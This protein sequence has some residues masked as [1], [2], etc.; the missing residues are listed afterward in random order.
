M[1]ARVLA[2]G[3]IALASVFACSDLKRAE[4]VPPGD[5]VDGGDV[6]PPGGDDDSGT[7]TTD[8]GGK[9][10][11]G[12]PPTDFECGDAW[13]KTTKA[14]KECEPR[15]V[16]IV[17][18]EIA[19]DVPDVSIT[20]TSAGRIGIAYHFP[21]NADEGE[22]HLAHF[23]PTSPTFTAALIK[24][25]LGPY[26][27]AGYAVKLAAS[28]P[29][30]IHVLSHDVIDASS[31]DV[32]HLKLVAGK[33]PLT[34][35]ELVLSAVKPRTELGFAV[36]P[37]GNA[38]ATIRV[39]TGKTDA[40]GPIAKIA[41][42]KKTGGGAFTALPDVAS[43]LLPNE[44]PRTGEASLIVDANGT[45]NLLF[46]YCEVFAHSQ[47]RY[48]T[49]D[50]SSWSYRKTVDN[51]IIDGLSGYSP[52]VAEH[53][54]KKFAAYY[55]RKA[56]QSPPESADLRLASWSL[57][58][59]TPTIEILD[60]TIPSLDAQYPRYRVAMA[61]DVFGLVHLAIVRPTTGTKGYLE[62]RRQTRVAGGGVKWL[63]DIVDPDVLSESSDALVD[64]VVDDKGRPHIAYRSGVDLK[65]RYASRYDR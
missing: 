42:R 9:I 51:A 7:S 58:T 46:H 19:I 53:N 63:S 28:A 52:R 13:T 4:E 36:D 5:D 23:T 41:A 60:Q 1:R 55:F 15:Q 14:K 2:L 6:T 20:R 29:D 40:G 25:A 16:K 56:L 27:Q 38:V 54:G 18:P 35:P 3:A 26:S 62:Y 11:A 30:T 39:Q 61:V 50:G 8:G 44:A 10:D 22:M 47:P 37:A 17:D 43:G 33:E 57:A 59:D 65:V 24:R 45:F 21:T 32:V 48:H 64:L 34:D 12:P 31:G 49:L